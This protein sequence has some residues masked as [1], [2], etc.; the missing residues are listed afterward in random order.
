MYNKKNLSEINHRYAG[1]Y[2]NKRDDEGEY[3][4]QE[5]RENQEYH[6]DYEEN[7]NNND[8]NGEYNNENYENNNYY[9]ED[10]AENRE[11]NVDNE[12][13][14]VENNDECN[15]YYI[16]L[17]DLN[18]QFNFSEQPKFQSH[19][20]RPNSNKI[21]NNPLSKSSNGTNKYNTGA[22][23]SYGDICKGILQ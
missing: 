17:I 1:Q 14:E 2:E 20:E 7:N 16:I 5:D 9:E 11:N 21:I 8:N 13:Q 22:K 19:N 6:E 12:N 18:H 23:A 10:D 4:N 15:N 3:N